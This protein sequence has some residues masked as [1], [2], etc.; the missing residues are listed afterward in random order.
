MSENTYFT[1]FSDFRR[2]SHTFYVFLEWRFKTRSSA[3]AVIADRTACSILTLFIV[4]ATSRHL[5]KQSVCYKSAD[6]T[7][8]GDLRL[9]PQS[10]V[11][12]PLSA[13]AVGS[14]T[15]W[16]FNGTV[17][18]LTNEPTLSLSPIDTYGVSSAC[19]FVF[20]WCIVWLNDTSYSKSVW[21]DK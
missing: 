8:T 11:R 4:T 1:F 15:V 19:Q 16:P 10:A 21:M 12:T 9:R 2:L 6:P 14:R 18:L 20:L 5:N 3:I 17:S 7:I 13:P